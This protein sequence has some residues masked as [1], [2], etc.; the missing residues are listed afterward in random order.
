MSTPITNFGKVTVSTGYDAAATSIVLS[1]GHGSRLPSTFPF[2][3]TWWNATD[4]GDPADDTNKEIVTVTNRSS[5]TLTVTRGAEGTSASTKNTGGKTYKM[6]LGITKAMWDALTVNRALSQTFRGVQVQPHPDADKAVTQIRLVHADAIVMND[7]EEVADWND[8]D[9]NLAAATG[10]GGLDTGTEQNA[11]WYKIF[12]MWNGTTK[13][14]MMQRAKNYLLDTQYITGEDASQ[15]IRSAV[16]NSTVKVSQG[17][18]FGVAGLLEFVDL[19]LI[20][21]GTP[22]GFLWVTLE[23][24]NGGVPS[25]TPLATSDKID[26][27]RLS[28]AA[29]WVRIPFRTPYSAS[30]ATQYHLV[31]QGD[32]TISATNFVSVR[33]DGS[34]GTYALG[35]KA[36]FDSDTSTW[37]TDT[38][39][40]LQF[41]T[42]ITQNDTA[43]VVPTGYRYAHIGWAFNGNGGDVAPFRQMN[44]CCMY[45]SQSVA[46]VVNEL[47]AAVTLYD[48]RNYLPPM[49]VTATFSVSGTGAASATAVLGDLK[50][51]DTVN[52]AAG[53]FM[54]S[55]SSRDTAEIASGTCTP[56]VLEYNVVMVD[57]TSGADLYIQSFEF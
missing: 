39:D 53:P 34:A 46:Q 9:V 1:S 51:T 15:G 25:N 21:T 14:V 22:G 37:T 6:V 31:L 44:R 33:M 30:V 16:D 38:D 56:I 10:I 2:P 19:K 26:V 12:A 24:N 17:V 32:W 54:A 45:A 50:G 55:G 27:S 29:T 4:N 18:Q 28:T 48:L 5:D 40:D 7:G 23:A 57:A 43:L 42:Y 47:A 41:T 13:G 49:T 3:L 36:L 52:A 20:K 8:L 35:S 11:T